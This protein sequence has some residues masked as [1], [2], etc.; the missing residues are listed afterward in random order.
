MRANKKEKYERALIGV[1]GKLYTIF[2]ETNLFVFRTIK[3]DF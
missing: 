1:L 2:N 3:N